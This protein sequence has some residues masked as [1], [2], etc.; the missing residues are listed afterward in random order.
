MTERKKILL[1]DDE[2]DFCFFVK[3]ILEQ[4][5]DFYVSC[6]TNPNKGIRIARQETPDLILL[7]VLMPKRDGF[8]TLEILKENH[9]TIGIPVIMLTAVGGDEA[10]IKASGFYCDGYIT[11]PVTFETLKTKID[12]VF[13]LINGR[14]EMP[15]E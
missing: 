1:I 15:Q 4:T 10:K 9:K 7:D 13:E 8:K 2:K 3:N 11:K 6:A 5:G 12:A 14:K